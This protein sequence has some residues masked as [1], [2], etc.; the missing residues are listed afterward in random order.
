MS[1]HF[2]R[3]G[4]QLVEANNVVE[5]LRG[6]VARTPIT[7][8]PG[9]VGRIPSDQLLRVGTEEYAEENSLRCCH[10]HETRAALLHSLDEGYQ[11]S[12]W[13]NGRRAQLHCCSNNQVVALLPDRIPQASDNDTVAVGC[14]DRRIRAGGICNDLSRGVVTLD[15]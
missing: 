12:V 3:G 4:R 1:K 13:S 5:L 6:P 10:R 8:Y 11:Q 9:P 7:I 2:R 15:W 14:R